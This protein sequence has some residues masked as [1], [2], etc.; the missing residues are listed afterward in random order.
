LSDQELEALASGRKPQASPSLEDLSD[1]ELAQLAGEKPLETPSLMERVGGAALDGVVKAG[2]FVDS[3]TG[4][5]TR[6]AIGA[7]QEG[8]NPLSAFVGQFGED[9]AKAPTGKDIVARE[10]VSTEENIDLPLLGKVSPAG[11]A[12][13]A[14]DV[15]ADPT[16]L[17][18]GM[19]L[20]KGGVR[21]AKATAQGAGS[22]LATA[23]KGAGKLAVRTGEA[24]EPT[25]KASQIGAVA[26]DTAKAAKRAMDDF[27]Q[28]KQ[29]QDFRHYVDL[30]ERNGIDPRLLPESI[31]FGEGS[32]V[33]RIARNVRE[34]PLVG[35]ME[36][37]RFR[38]GLMQVDSAVDNKLAQIGGGPP[39][40]DIEAGQVIKRGYEA[41]VDKL[42]NEDAEMTYNQVIKAWPG[43]ELTGASRER[44]SSKLAGIEKWAKGRIS[45]GFTA[46]DREQGAQVLRAVEAVKA[47]NGS[48]KQTYETMLD[49]GR[50]AYRQTKQGL[51]DTPPDIEKFRDLYDTLS[52][53]FVATTRY[54]DPNAAKALENTNKT[55]HQFLKAKEPIAK[56][57]DNERIAPEKLF[58][59]IVV[60]GDSTKLAA[61]KEMLSPEE[62]NRLRASYVER[63][64]TRDSDGVINFRSLR[65]ALQKD[66][67]TLSALFSPEEI[68]DVI[69]L[70]KMG[71]KW[72]PA[73]LSTS[74]TG[75]SNILRD[76]LEGLKSGATNRA[77]LDF[78]KQK[79]RGGTVPSPAARSAP[80]SSGSA[81]GF[82]RPVRNNA[83]ETAKLLQILGTI[84]T[85]RSREEQSATE[86]RMEEIVRKRLAK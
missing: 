49:I 59:N 82:R 38:A 60:G 3:Y 24:V 39:L 10:G 41:R 52:Q 71:E 34:N 13:F 21:A 47:G 40:T 7:L 57:L 74:G 33:S 50:V 23:A 54:I 2:Q 27:F 42:F 86:R 28:P 1:D 26:V 81:L 85:G 8:K 70:A 6:S 61:L 44:V 22:A 48:L 80:Q 14:V 56:L 11:I 17:L 35:E 51:G 83:E 37:E 69:E 58:R 68:G 79:A 12:G 65:N 36:M 67:S 19:T 66:T 15:A 45:R 75:A 63:Y 46:T 32:S 18:P 78:M 31:E 53:E 30:A 72:G 29:A 4:A 55:I 64:I 43:I 20:A 25:L 77:T 76:S 62:F 16:N 5:P 9:P 73:V 84:G